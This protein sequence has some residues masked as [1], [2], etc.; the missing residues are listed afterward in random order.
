MWCFDCIKKIGE[1]ELNNIRQQAKL[2]AVT[3]GKAMAIY[4]EGSEYCFIAASEAIAGS[5]P[6]I[7]FVSSLP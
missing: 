5:Y 3:D 1:E 6:V 4:K 7:E 2:K